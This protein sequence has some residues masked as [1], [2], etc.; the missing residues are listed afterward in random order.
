[1]QNSARQQI[2]RPETL[3]EKTF[4]YWRMCQQF[5]GRR[6]AEED[7]TVF[8]AFQLINGMLVATDPSRPITTRLLDL[9]VDLIAN[10]TSPKK[11]KNRYDKK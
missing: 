7:L 10:N 9:Q 2:K 3:S 6:D 4:S 1:M 5:Y 11:R 8:N